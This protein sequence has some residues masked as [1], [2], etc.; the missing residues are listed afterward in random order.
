VQIVSKKQ[1]GR[2]CRQKC[3]KKRE[4]LKSGNWVGIRE[5]GGAIKPS[6]KNKR[7][8]VEKKERKKV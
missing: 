6:R 5:K 2:K 8:G 7:E 3:F 1:G 4:T